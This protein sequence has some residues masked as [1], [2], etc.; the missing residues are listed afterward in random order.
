MRKRGLKDV[1]RRNRQVILEAVMEQEG[2]SR[3][4]IA[5]NTGLA[6]STVS[7]LVGELLSEGVLTE[8]GSVV[9]AGRSRTA[10]TVNPAHGSIAV[11]EIGRRESRVTAFDMA[12]KPLG[13]TVLSRRYIS[14]N[15]LL[16]RITRA[17]GDWQDSLPPILG[18]GLLF[19]EDMRESDFRVVYSTYLSADS[20][21]LREALVTQF[22]VPVE[23]EYS[24][25]YTV[26]NALAQEADTE[27]R[28]SAHISVGSRVLARVTLEG[29]EVPLRSSFCQELLPALDQADSAPT[30][31]LLEGLMQLILLLCT[32]FPLDTVFLSGAALPGE[33]A[34]EHL[35]QQVARTLNQAPRL[36]FLHPESPGEGTAVMARQVLRK[37]LVNR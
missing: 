2:L 30:Q 19:Q 4:E 23:E 9:T 18:I 27:A 14:G 37:A 33:N 26:S 1:K 16:E 10:L 6:A 36:R 21:T 31:S 12:L 15:D 17:L 3:V 5:Q 34:L 25:T 35:T 8:A 22:R 7:T 28:N 13:T 20:I 11:V 29:R 24:L 32:L